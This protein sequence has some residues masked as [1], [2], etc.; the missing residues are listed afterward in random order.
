MI[1][2]FSVFYVGNID[3]EDVGLDGIPANDR[4]YRN[5]RLTQSMETAEKAAILM[6]ELGY[7]ALWMA[8]H[9]FQREG[10]ECIPNV[11]MMGTHLAAKTER[12]KFGCGFNIVPMWHPLRLAEDYAMADVLTGGR[13]IFGVG[14]GYHSREVETF[15]SPVIDN[16]LN[17]ELFEEQIEVILKAFNSESF[18]HHGKNYNIPPDVP[19][20]G[21]DLEEITLVPRPLNLPVETWQPVVSGSSIDF[22]VKNGFNGVV[23]LTGEKLVDQAFH[24]FRDACERN[25][26]GNVLGSGLALGIGFYIADNENDAMERLRPFHDERFKWFA[27]FGFVRYADEE[28]RVWGTPGAPAR[29]P[30]IE[31]GVQQKAWICGPPSHQI[32]FLKKV[33]EKYP[34]LENIMLHWP[35]GMPRDEYL[36]QLRIF[37]EEVMPAFTGRE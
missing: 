35:E 2:N 19:Y 16:D 12:L 6:D 23:A 13:M 3:L 8:E 15:G 32:E 20:R 25:G 9:H 22:T 18:S 31:D 4:R 28:G 24:R 1:K 26:R 10:Y 36:S 21:Y 11:I 33:E 14:R 5:E 29:T 27:P 17:R 34:G 30:R 7:H 37:A